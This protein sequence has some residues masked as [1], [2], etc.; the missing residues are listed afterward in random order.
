MTIL[1]LGRTTIRSIECIEPKTLM[2]C[3]HLWIGTMFGMKFVPYYCD[4]KQQE[5][6]RPDG[7]KRCKYFKTV[8]LSNWITERETK[9]D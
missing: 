9:N 1:K 8:D 6:L 7:K 5:I 2:S 4:V 3:N